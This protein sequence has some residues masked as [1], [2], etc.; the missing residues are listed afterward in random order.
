MND[1]LHRF[2][3]ARTFRSLRQPAYRSFF[4]GQILSLV[5]TWMQSMA[6][7][8]LVYEL[9]HSPVWLGTVGFLNTVPMLFFALY[10]GSVADRYPRHRIIVITQMLSL[11]QAVILTSVVMLGVVTVEMVCVLAFTLGTINAFDVPA[12]QAFVVELVGRENFANAIALNS[13]AFNSARIV[14][15]AIGGLVI[16]VAGVGWCFFINAVSFVAVLIVLLRMPRPAA[17]PAQEGKTGI[18]PGLKES[19]AYVRS[20]REMIVVFLLVAVITIF[21]WSY[22]VLLP[23]FADTILHIGA[24]GLGNLMMAFGIG[25]VISA[26]AVASLEGKINPFSFLRTGILLFLVGVSV[27]ALSSEV[28]YSIPALIVVGMGLIMFISTANAFIQRRVPD[29]MRGRVLGLYLLIFQGMA[30]FGHYGMGWLAHLNGPRWAVLSGAA[31]CAVSAI[32]IRSISGRGQRP[33]T[34]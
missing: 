13:A 30:P 9:T 10:G 25:A 15:P 1:L 27:L 24:V 11:L 7:S 3:S 14:G 6:Q 21:G 29:G 20:D 18:L 32:M 22:T 23:L 34:L 2:L 19:V 8:W 26:V 12:R 4:S 5:G 33:T 16:G 17:R 31:V 28:L